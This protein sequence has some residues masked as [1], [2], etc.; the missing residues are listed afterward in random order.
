MSQSP[1]PS[2]SSDFYGEE[3][4]VEVQVQVP[5]DK[6]ASDGSGPASPGSDPMP[7]DESSPDS[8]DRATTSS[9]AVTRKR[10]HSLDHSEPE[11][12][13]K[14]NKSV[15]V[16]EHYFSTAVSGTVGLPAELWQYIFLHLPPD[17]LSSCLRVNK[18]FY[19]YL[20]SVAASM[21]AAL[22]PGRSGL[23]LMDF[24]AIWTSARKV[25]APNL[26]RPLAGFSEMQMFQ[27]LG[28]KYCE[29]CG[30]PPT[31]PL[32]ARTPF[33]AGPGPHGVRIIWSF[34]T[35][36]CGQCFEAMSLKDTAILQ[37]AAAPL[38]AGLPH[39]FRTHDSHYIPA[40]T[41]QANPVGAS[42]GAMFKVYFRKHVQELQGEYRE[43][44]EFGEAAAE[45]WVKGLPLNGKQQ[46]ADAARWERWEALQPPGSHPATTLREYFRPVSTRPAPVSHPSPAA[47]SPAVPTAASAAVS[48]SSGTSLPVL[49]SQPMKHPLPA[50]VVAAVTP[51]SPAVSASSAEPSVVPL[52]GRQNGSTLQQYPAQSQQSQLNKPQAPAYRPPRNP[53]E[54]EEARAARKAD[55]E[56]RAYEEFYPPL[57]PNVLQH[58]ESFRAALQI[59][60]PLIDQAWEVLKPRL[61]MQRDAAEQIEYQR[62]E[63][64]RALQ[65]TIPD[66][67]YRDAYSKSAN[68]AAERQWEH[69]QGP[70]R[71]KLGKL[72][73][74]FIRAK[75][76]D[77]KGLTRDT[78][79]AFAVEVLLYARNKHVERNTPKDQ[80]NHEGPRSPSDPA[81]ISLENMRWLFDN[82]VKTLTERHCRELFMCAEC[83]GITKGY[84]FEGL[85]QHFG[86]KHTSDFS[87]GNIVV[88]WQTADWPD[89]P[90][91]IPT[92]GDADPTL[93]DRTASNSATAYTA[94][95]LNGARSHPSGSDSQYLPYVAPT[96]ALSSLMPGQ[97]EQLYV[98]LNRQEAA[99]ALPAG[100]HTQVHDPGRSLSYSAQQPQQ[101]S[102]Q[103]DASHPTLPSSMDQYQEHLDKIAKVARKIW[104]GIAGVKSMVESIKMQTVLLHVI[105]AF[106]ARYT[107][108]PSLDLF[109]DALANH[110]LMRP[111]KDAHPLACKT[112]ISASLGSTAYKPYHHRLADNKSYS[113]SSLITHFK[114]VHLIGQDADSVDWKEDMIEMADE[115]QI[116]GLVSAIGMDDDKLAIIAA[117]FPAVFPHP[118]PRIGKIAA[119]EVA[120]LDSDNGPGR[121]NKFNKKE[122]KK[123]NNKRS[124]QVAVEHEEAEQSDLPEAGEDE[125]DPRRPA[126]IST[127]AYTSHGRQLQS[128]AASNGNPTPKTSVLDPSVLTPETLAALSKLAPALNLTPS[129]SLGSVNAVAN[130]I[131]SAPS[132]IEATPARN[133]RAAYHPDDPAAKHSAQSRRRH[134]QEKD[135]RHS[136][137]E[138]GDRDEKKGRNRRSGAG[139]SDREEPTEPEEDYTQVI[140][141]APATGG[142]Y[143]STSLAQHPGLVP[144]VS[145]TQL[146]DRTRGR[147]QHAD[148]AGYSNIPLDQYG[149]PMPPADPYRYEPRERVQYVDEY[150]RPIQYA[151]PPREEVRYVDQ[152][153]RTVEVVRVVERPLYDRGPPPMYEYPQPHQAHPHGHVAAAP[154]VNA[155]V[156]VMPQHHGHPYA[157]APPPAPQSGPEYGWPPPAEH[158]YGRPPTELPYDPRRERVQY[159]D[160]YGRPIPYG[161]PAY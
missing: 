77:G 68:E 25:F 15:T 44:K 70:I 66:P 153:G 46:M 30:H 127:P 2:D 122:K 111:I 61:Y 133:Q 91:F 45:E 27:L 41:L 10:K 75:W 5:H 47:A 60:T 88:H 48:S 106:K 144:A 151:P 34:S 124:R 123:K 29:I 79:P 83:E 113:I 99:P 62:G 101:I 53:R 84:A 7:M 137:K 114:T 147:S 96:A 43:A 3:G 119:R 42:R 143:S 21:S 40:T 141:T 154:A 37:S 14:R 105:K 140:R 107:I 17:S 18:G 73:E 130:D 86:A 157:S 142:D 125:Y 104:D 78:A 112:C 58:M 59:V 69:Q 132:T 57:M 32:N 71:K 160:E 134:S 36:I 129:A 159:I 117:V 49:S 110:I 146:I 126:F 28:G 19:I 54:V 145:P 76:N 51:T 80:E 158:D 89:D 9:T 52:S 121:Y 118:L 92:I 72:A 1:A 16:P 65:A 22:P 23:K 95:A 98:A 82:K 115:V 50:R 152:Y 90:P 33:D 120:S 85:I 35:R 97:I 103:T 63:Q 139:M 4:E 108:E 26:P 38:R 67:S 20:T 116:S 87:Q 6:V 39:A 56:R 13:Q 81:F 11:L 93:P 138:R 156:P 55:I 148:A 136:K 8:P 135:K 155:A 128:G 24:D 149:Q 131:R 150:G 102:A 31:A 94:G 161:P 12:A 74:E 100:I 64:L 109:T